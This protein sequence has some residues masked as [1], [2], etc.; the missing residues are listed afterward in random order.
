MCN[1]IKVKIFYIYNPIISC[2]MTCACFEHI[3]RCFHLRKNKHEV[4]DKT[5]PNYNKVHK[6][7]WLLN[8]M[9]DTCQK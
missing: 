7:H 2:T 5:S 8:V 3:I 9:R 6:V 1:H 4:M